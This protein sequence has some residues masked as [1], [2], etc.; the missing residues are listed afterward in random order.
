MNVLK[1]RCLLTVLLS[2]AALVYPSAAFAQA[3]TVV[4]TTSSTYGAFART[5]YTV[6][7]TVPDNQ[8]QVERV[9]LS[10]LQNVPLQPVVLEPSLGNSAL[11][12]TLGNSST[13]ADFDNSIAATLAGSALDVYMYSPRETFLAPGA[14]PTPTSCPQASTWGLAS[15]VSDLNFILGLSSLRRDGSKPVIGGVS[16]G[17]MIGIAAVD[18][19]PDSFAG[20]LL[21]DSP[22]WISS[23]TTLKA[24]YA[25]LCSAEQALIASGQ[26]VNGQLDS[27]AQLIVQL[28]V[29]DPSG[30]SPIPLFPPGTTN[31]QAY[32]DFWEAPQ[33]GPPLS[34]F[35]PGFVLITGNASSFYVASQ[36]R[37]DAS[38]L[39]FNYYVTNQTV[40]DIACSFGGETTFVGNLAAFDKPVLAMEF[41]KAF[42]PIDNDVLA[43]MGTK[44]PT[45][46]SYPN[47]GHVDSLTSAN[48]QLLLDDVVV[49]WTYADVV[50]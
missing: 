41:Q 16:L 6:Y 8:F 50:F 2:L 20:L 4:Q 24:N 30:V 13:G 7:N 46:V 14:C 39:S 3:F 35:L 19:S 11:E 31:Q 45:V 38:V 49:A 43:L 27:V 44:N 1:K 37:V 26:A 25:T 32:F 42:G 23:N 48:H 36:P 12:Y 29:S 17:G 40:A 5:T 9:V 10:S 47:F 34:I 33:P 15:D 18:Q 21:G 22:L 28:D